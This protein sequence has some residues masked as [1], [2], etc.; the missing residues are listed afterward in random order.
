MQVSAF[1]VCCRR[2]LLVPAT[3]FRLALSGPRVNAPCDL[4]SGRAFHFHAC[5]FF[6]ER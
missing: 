1:L 3:S 2:I 5:P 6:E 4:I